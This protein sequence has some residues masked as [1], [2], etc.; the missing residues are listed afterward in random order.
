[1]K[2]KFEGNMREITLN[3][4]KVGI[5]VAYSYLQ[6]VF[7]GDFR[8]FIDQITSASATKNACI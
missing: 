6:N 4:V 5:N 3:R 8:S 1:M 2:S 7:E